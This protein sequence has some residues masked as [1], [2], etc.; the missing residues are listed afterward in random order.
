MGSSPEG[1]L[2]G[3]SCP[4]CEEGPTREFYSQRDIP[5][6]SC[7]MV[8]NE[9]QARAFPRGQLELHH[10]RSCGF[11][12]NARFQD[13]R[14]R[15][16]ADYEETQGFSPHFQRFLREQAAD[17]VERHRLRGRTALEIG[18]GKGE[19]LELL[20]DSGVA[21]GIGIDPSYRP[22]RTGA[23]AKG[24]LQFHQDLYS[25]RYGHLAADLVACRH[26]LEHIAEPRRFMDTVRRAIGDRPD[27]VVFFELPELRRIL[28]EC[29]FWDIYYE[30]CSYFSAG[31]LARLF[32]ATGFAV[33]RIALDYD[34]QYLL[35]ESRPVAEPVAE[36]HPDEESLEEL[37]AEVCAFERTMQDRL[38]TWREELGEWRRRGWTVVLWGSGSK[39]VSYL[40]TLGVG[41]EVR[42]VVDINPHKHGK[43]LAGTAHRIGAPAELVSLRP[44]LVLVMNPVYRQEIQQELAGLGVQS[45][46]RTL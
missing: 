20:V 21:S 11:V 4:C 25:E 2:V 33:D 32:R 43:F 39:A 12:F 8:E 24:R 34:D 19:F 13:E 6:H 40:T 44:D 3:R 29:A 23:E 14:M 26:T 45:E 28:R 31:S 41:D 1:P 17:L 46:V 36:P 30:H 18:C 10:C 5:I 42:L 22:E 27:T 37:E 35:L 7:L 16:S 9:E 15:Y 38:V